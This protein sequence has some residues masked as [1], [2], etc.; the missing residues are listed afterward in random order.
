MKSV[1]EVPVLGAIGV[2]SHCGLI[3]A[4]IELSLGEFFVIEVP[5]LG[6]ISTLHS[7]SICPMEL[8]IDVPELGAI[9]ILSSWTVCAMELVIEVP[10]LGAIGMLNGG[11]ISTMEFAIEPPELG[12]I[13]IL[14][15]RTIC[16]M[17]LIIEI[18]A[19][20]AIG[21]DDQFFGDFVLAVGTVGRKNS[22]NLGFCK[23]NSI[24]LVRKRAI[25]VLSC[26]I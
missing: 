23:L 25:V 21:I 3:Y 16:A 10:V 20:G 12:A 24:Y 26:S 22:F 7:W 4:L 13:G 5:V 18:V 14:N 9:S 11:T 19:L 1:I 6:A 15:S 2:G 17:K 8:T